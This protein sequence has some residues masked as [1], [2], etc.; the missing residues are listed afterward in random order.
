MVKPSRDPKA[1]AAAR[2]LLSDVMGQWPRSPDVVAIVTDLGASRY[3][4]YIAKR[5]GVPPS[6]GVIDYSSG[7]TRWIDPALVQ[8]PAT[9]VSAEGVIDAIAERPG[10]GYDDLAKVL[11]VTKPTARRY[12]ENLG[13]AV[14]VR[15]I[16][17]TA[18]GP[19]ERLGLFAR[20]EDPDQSGT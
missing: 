6:E 13:D 12:V 17:S 3:D 10:I 18:T 5:R 19:R 15:T 11:N 8:T 16:P 1:K 2:R 4:W 7:T 20:P 9:K 14:E